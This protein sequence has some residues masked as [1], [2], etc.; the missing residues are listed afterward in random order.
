[1]W[2][3]EHSANTDCFLGWGHIF[4]NAVVLFCKLR[5]AVCELWDTRFLLWYFR[6]ASWPM[7]GKKVR[8]LL[9]VSFPSEFSVAGI[10]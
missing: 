9:S 2:L 3:V 5:N 10:G 4:C 6:F 1:M 7:S 8:A